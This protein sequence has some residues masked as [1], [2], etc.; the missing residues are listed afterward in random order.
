MHPQARLTHGL[1]RSSSPQSASGVELTQVPVPPGHSST[2]MNPNEH[3][4]H[5][6]PLDAGANSGTPKGFVAINLED[7]TQEEIG[8]FSARASGAAPVRFST[9]EDTPRIPFKEHVFTKSKSLASLVHFRLTF[10]GQWCVALVILVVLFTLIYG[11][12]LPV[13]DFFVSGLAGFLLGDEAR[14]SYS[15]LDIAAALPYAVEPVLDSQ[16]VAIRWIQAMFLLF[17][18]LIPILFLVVIF[19][20]W[21]VPLASSVQYLLFR[22][23]EIVFAWTALEALIVAML[24]APTQIG[25]LSS[26]IVGDKCDGLD[27]LL[28]W[29]MSD[30]LGDETYCFA[31][32]GSLLPG[33]GV[34]FTTGVGFIFFGM[35]FQSVINCVIADRWENEKQQIYVAHGGLPSPVPSSDKSLSEQPVPDLPSPLRDALSG[36]LYNFVLTMHLVEEVQ[37]GKAMGGR[38]RDSYKTVTGTKTK[39]R[40]LSAIGGGE[41]T[42]SPLEQL[43]EEEAKEDAR[44]RQNQ[45]VEVAEKDFMR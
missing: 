21:M 31:V 29:F 8:D 2:G 35:W 9:T 16:S 45:P 15:V 17:S 13:A 30:L 33:F 38:V 25:T 5:T 22:A 34:L 42:K 43:R 44:E 19:V 24:A 23:S 7:E 6:D 4:V 32:E 1:S 36:S 3:E 41:V 11:M 12:T 14:Q 40:T 10:G 28:T 26:F 39:G 37:Q 18:I 20:L 27:K